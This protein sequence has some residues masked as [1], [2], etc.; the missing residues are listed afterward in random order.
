MRAG[1]LR[2]RVT[3]QYRRPR[4]AGVTDANTWETYCRTWA[5]IEPQRGRELQDQET[6]TGLMTYRIIMRYRPGISQA[7]RIKWQDRYF[8]IT[9]V[10]RTDEIEREIILE[11]EEYE[12]GEDGRA[13]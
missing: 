8:R 11:A 4:G 7:M 9:E 10:A 2:H 1:R 13:G 12:G 5:A 3:V 6:R